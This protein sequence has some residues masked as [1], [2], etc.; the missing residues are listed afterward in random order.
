MI[1]ILIN[2]QII[3]YCYETK[4]PRASVRGCVY[5]R[6]CERACGGFNVRGFGRAGGLIVMGFER[7]GI[8]ACG[9]L[10]MRGFERA[11]VWACGGFSVRGFERAGVWACGGLSVR[12]FERAGVLACGGLLQDCFDVRLQILR[13][14]ITAILKC[15]GEEFVPRVSREI[16]RTANI[17]LFNN[18]PVPCFSLKEKSSKTKM[19]TWYTTKRTFL[20]PGLSSGDDVFA[21]GASFI[22]ST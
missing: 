7:A 15:A 16:K 22:N 9:G 6:L 8:W 4:G 13:K 5:T 19:S 17:C 21:K 3:S 14:K 10:S 1:L 2:M 20:Q 11:G 12:G 18:I